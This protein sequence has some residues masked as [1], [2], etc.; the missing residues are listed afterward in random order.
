MPSS[1]RRRRALGDE[2]AVTATLPAST[3]AFYIFTS[4]TTGLPKASVMSHNR[5]L[6]NMAGIGGMA[7]RLRHS[8]TMYIP[9]PLYH[10]NALS[11]SLGSVLAGARKRGHRQTVLRVAVLGRHHSQPCHRVLLHRRACRY[12][13]AQPPKPTDRSHGVRR[14]RGQRHA[15]GDPGRVQRAFRHQADRRVLRCQRAEPGLRQRVH[16]RED[17]RLRPLPFKVVEYDQETGERRD[18]KGVCVRCARAKAGPVDLEI[19]SR[20]PLDGYT[21]SAATEK[22]IIRDG[23]KDG[24]L[25]Q[26]GTWSARSAGATSPLSTARRHVPLEG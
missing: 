13:L 26:P 16:R 21:D 6:A 15:P 14:Q 23:F 24:D 1:T 9:L 22:K 17:R 18:A 2:P 7:V 10:N 19:S 25:V 3:N 8:D 11:V 20:V 5:W 4:G 12:L